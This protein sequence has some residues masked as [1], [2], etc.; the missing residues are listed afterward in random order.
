MINYGAFFDELE[1]VAEEKKKFVTKDKLKRG[2]MAAGLVGV[3][4]GLGHA[5]GLA[6][7]RYM[8]SRGSKQLRKVI[9]ASKLSK[10]LPTAIGVAS[11]GL[12]ALQALKAKKVKDFIEKKNEQPK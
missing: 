9:P 3:G 6:F 8:R 12:A 1:K 11:G 10:F 5:S 2:V 4:T 7:R